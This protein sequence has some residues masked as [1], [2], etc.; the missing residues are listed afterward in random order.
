MTFMGFPPPPGAGTAGS[1]APDGPPDRER[2]AQGHFRTVAARPGARIVGRSL[3][4]FPR[5]PGLLREMLTGFSFVRS[6]FLAR[7]KKQ[8]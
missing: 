7:A 1:A 8:G 3:F 2:R 5:P 6:C 4:S